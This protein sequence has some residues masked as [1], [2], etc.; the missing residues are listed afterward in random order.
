MAKINVLDQSV[1][2]KI[3]AGEV[4]EKP[5]SVVKELVENSLDAGATDILVSIANGGISFIEV[6]DNGSGIEKDQLEKVFLPH[7][8]S[9]IKDAED[10]EMITSLG[11][12]GEAMASIASVAMVSLESSTDG[13]NAFRISCDGGKLSGIMQCTRAN[14]TTV[15]VRN[16]F[17]N[18]PARL[19]FLR[20]D[21]AEERDIVSILEKIAFANPF[22]R[23]ELR[24][25][26]KLV[27]K[28]NGEG[29]LDSIQSIYGKDISANLLEINADQY[30]MRLTGFIS[31][32]SYSKPTRNYQT[33]IVNNRVVN[34]VS[35]VTAL[36][37]VYVDYFVKRTYPFCVLSLTVNP[38]E[39]DVNVHPAKTE[40]KFEYQSKVYSFIQRHVRDCLMDSLHEKNIVFGEMSGVIS[41]EW[42]TPFT[43]EE[44][45]EKKESENILTFD[46]EF[47]LNCVNLTKIDEARKK[48]YQKDKE[49][50]YRASLSHEDGV[51]IKVDDVFNLNRESVNDDSSFESNK[52]ISFD[53]NFNKDIKID[54]SASLS[55]H[56]QQHANTS[57]NLQKQE[58]IE[59]DS[60]PSLNYDYRIVGQI[61]GTY[62]V[63][64]FSDYIMLIDQHAAA[65]YKLYS[66]YLNMIKS[67][68]ME[69]Q[70]LL[71]PIPLDLDRGIANEFEEKIDLLSTIGIE[72]KKVSD[73]SYEITAI[74]VLLQEIDSKA[75]IANIL[76]EDAVDLPLKERLM[77]KACRAAIKGNTNLD[78]ESIELF[79][80]GMFSDG[81][82]PKC[83]HGR[84]SYVKISKSEIEKLFLRIV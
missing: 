28:T 49:S 61:F 39:I 27:F 56:L 71:L 55:S 78:N 14:G 73:L 22:T 21:K 2:N 13:E 52:P 3:S 69:I 10:L 44:T 12:R 45:N 42:T 66:G 70:P 20:K 35:I 59:I 79:I 81:M 17:F 18:T 63:L 80:K 41:D 4:V 62:I 11:F 58:K 7:A 72:V 67:N 6:S 23:F 76:S 5:A 25:D 33:F 1:Y 15:T 64:E 40:I 65:E 82:F 84:P 9:K 24:A 19:K 83:P 31:N 16:L 57:K 60:A 46:D 29:L 37:N 51:T 26:N 8:T 48:A 36:N 30:G 50:A 77:Y 47:G 74:P 68:R 75:L 43:S 54:D 38:S 53:F 32:T 34:N